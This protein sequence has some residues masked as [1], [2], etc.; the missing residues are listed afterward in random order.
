VS[1]LIFNAANCS[2]GEQKMSDIIQNATMMAA[3]QDLARGVKSERDL[4]TLA[5]DLLKITF[6]RLILD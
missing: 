4:A 5:Q 3:L 1:P 6:N 2:Q